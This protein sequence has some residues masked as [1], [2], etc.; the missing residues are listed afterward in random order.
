MGLSN[1]LI[2]QFAKVV[3]GDKADKKETTLRG[4]T[5]VVGEETYVKL[6]GSDI[7]TPVT[8]TTDV[9]NEERVTVMIKDH[10]ATITGN[11]SSPAARTDDVTEIGNQ[12]SEFEIIVA[13]KVSTKQLEAQVGRIDDLVSENVTIKERL[14][15]G[16]ASIGE[17]EAD[18]VTINEKLVANDAEIKTLKAEKIDA[19]FLVG[20]YATVENL[21]AT[22][23]DIHNL[24]AD[25]GEFEQLVS[26]DLS[27][28]NADIDNLQATKL[29]A[30]D[31]DLKYATIANLEAESARI[32]TL[33]ADVA[34]IDTLIFG[35][36]SGDVIQ[37]SFAN[38]VIAQLGNAQIKSAMIE[39][40][41]AGQITAG[42]IITSNVRV[43]SEDGSLI[44]SDETIQIS[45]DTRVRVQI[46]K[47]ASNDYSINIWDA[48]GN[49]MFSEGGI[50]DSAIKDAIIRNDMVSEDANISASKLNISSLFT[51][52]NGSTETINSTK[53]YLDDKA[54]TLDVAFTSLSSD[55]DDMSNTVSS[56]G[57]QISTIQ[58]Q[59]TSKIWQQDIDEATGELSTQYSTLEQEVDGISATVASHTTEIAKKADSS[60]VT[61]VSDR[62]TSVEA[63]LDGFKSTVS[64]TYATKSA[65]ASTDTK[66]TNAQSVASSAQ[67][68][69]NAAKLDAEASQSAAEDADAKAAQAV[70]DLATAQQ[71]LANV[72][73]RVDATEEEI[74]E[75]QAAVTTAQSTADTAKANAAAAQTDAN[76]AKAVADQAQ[77]D[78]TAA[79]QAVNGLETRVTSAETSIS[80]NAE[81]I[82]LRA[83]KTEVTEAID[84]IEIG[85]RNLIPKSAMQSRTYY[86]EFE[87]TLSG[88]GVE[89]PAADDLICFT[90][91]DIF[92]RFAL[93]ETYTVSFKAVAEGATTLHFDFYPDSFYGTFG[94]P[95][96]SVS[97][98][99]KAYSLTGVLQN[100]YSPTEMN[101]RFFRLTS[102]P[103]YKI[104]I[105]DIKVE[106]GNKATDWTPAPEDIS[107][108]I[109]SAET[110]ITQNSEQILLRATKTEVTTAINDIEIGGRNLLR[111]TDTLSKWFIGPGSLTVDEE[112]DA[113]ANYP[114]ADAIRW[115]YLNCMVGDLVRDVNML[116][117]HTIT[118]S[119]WV[120]VEDADAW[121]AGTDGAGLYISIS[122]CASSES[123]T[124]TKYRLLE[125][126]YR[127]LESGKWTRLVYTLSVEDETF[128]TS[129]SG[130]V[131]AFF[132]QVQAKTTLPYSV[133]KLKLE[134]GNKATDWTPAPEDGD[135]SALGIGGRNLYLGTKTFD[136]TRTDEYYWQNHSNWAVADETYED[137][138]V[139]RRSS[140]WGGLAQIKTFKKDEIYTLSFYAKVDSGGSIYRIF[141]DLSDPTIDLKNMR[142]LAQSHGFG[143][144]L[145]SETQDGT[146]WS[147]YWITVQAT[148]DIEQVS[149]RIENTIDGKVLYLC[150]FK[151]EKGNRATDWTPA[152]EDMATSEEVETAQ[153]A[154]DNAQSTA[155]A[156]ETRVSSVELAIDTIKNAISTLIVDEN[157]QSAMT[158]TSDGWTFNISDIT[159][160]LDDT[161]SALTELSGRSDVADKAIENLNSIAADLGTKTAYIN[162]TTDDSGNPCI[163]LGKS[164]NDFKVRITNT[165]VEFLEGTSK[166]AYVSNK[167][168]YI[169][170]AV[171]KN[172]LQIGE[173]TGFVWKKRS[174]GNMGLRCIGG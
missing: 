125:Y 154:A 10:T 148:A 63:S 64:E 159:N 17:L 115:F 137:F 119:F 41:S 147:R 6:D 160:Q 171:I 138:I 87:N 103:N 95:N 55:V 100:H 28:I 29:S 97:T 75:A 139:M 40:V 141:R 52:I 126:K 150:G 106:K 39:S 45:D 153:T 69:A 165:A 146:A 90:S 3:N 30:D 110:S 92:Y 37:T 81:A 163:E 174:N 57:T 65:L 19:D 60:A 58:G 118:F 158:Q 27:A 173:G 33:D 156:T 169:E 133:K 73:S 111:N 121:A 26:G 162:M 42:D 21:E 78:A 4:T 25:Y 32:D 161:A 34:D 7:L 114:G 128:F 61:T 166:I 105:Y 168:L 66:A 20:K 130:D 2:S 102:S 16:E 85:G 149:L 35:S 15:A 54:Q 88:F 80:Q 72:T 91:R 82:E 104:D 94:A 170:R 8:T 116:Y 77:A 127:G 172:E 9:K 120:K 84:N 22:N 14:T 76:N 101:L 70:A 164:D 48:S 152:P 49:L 117:G 123:L 98:E 122:A 12:V 43:M 157:G 145:V 24:Q 74:A 67:A 135:M 99:V 143:Q 46:G 1:E 155:I 59:I 13:D 71:N 140:A 44:I 96:V 83:T 89:L 113:V 136:N 144:A 112:G 51:E 18:N 86:K 50:T 62:V 53:I 36:A 107:D 38:A 134:Y 5:V 151:L 124:R 23:A 132:V 129:G 93:D 142:V 108:R 167:T 31:A 68:A 109:S 47:D 11:T 79:Q 131:G 56:Q